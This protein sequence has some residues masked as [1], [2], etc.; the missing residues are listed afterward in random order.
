M[1]HRVNVNARL[2]GLLFGG[3]VGWWVG[4]QVGGLVGRRVGGL[5][6]WWVGGL[7]GWGRHASSPSQEYS[8]EQSVIVETFAASSAAVSAALQPVPS[9]SHSSSTASSVGLTATARDRDQGVRH[10]SCTGEIKI[11]S[12]GS[13]RD[14]VRAGRRGGGTVWAGEGGASV[15]GCCVRAAGTGD[16]EEREG[17]REV[18]VEAPLYDY[19][20][21]EILSL[22]G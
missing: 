21:G 13:N 4:R 2:G 11:E 20:P 16:A 22:A 5:V 12:V 6:G 17:E 1:E 14:R 9:Q 19:K 10:A 7:V 8:V 18:G 15:S 3:L